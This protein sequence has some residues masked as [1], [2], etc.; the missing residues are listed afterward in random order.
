MSYSLTAPYVSENAELTKAFVQSI[1]KAAELR[2]RSR[3]FPKMDRTAVATGLIRH[4]QPVIFDATNV[5][6]RRAWAVYFTKGRWIIHFY[7]ELPWDNVPQM[8]QAKMNAYTA[9]T[10]LHEAP[11]D[12]VMF[13]TSKVIKLSDDEPHNEVI[14][15]GALIG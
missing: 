13:D 15:A 3:T 8:I 10:I 4:V 9:H 6:H 2:V 14:D 7:L 1:P 12:I 11:A 5:E